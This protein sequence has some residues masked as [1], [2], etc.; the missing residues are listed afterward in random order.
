MQEPEETWVQSLGGG[1]SLG[2]GIWPPTQYTC[3]DNL[4]DSLGESLAGCSPRGRKELD[5]AEVPEHTHM[6]AGTEILQ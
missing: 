6:C 5:M 2:E 3:L 1:R 4:T